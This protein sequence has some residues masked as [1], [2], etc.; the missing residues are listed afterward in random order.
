MKIK[1]S[2][3]KPNGYDWKIESMENGDVLEV[4]TPSGR[5]LLFAHGQKTLRDRLN[6]EIEEHNERLQQYGASTKEYAHRNLETIEKAKFPL[7]DII[8]YDGGSLFS[9]ISRKNPYSSVTRANVVRWHVDLLNYVLEYDRKY[10]NTR[11][12][13]VIANF[14]AHLIDRPSVMDVFS[15]I[16]TV[17]SK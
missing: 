5:Y 17:K 2:L 3:S 6:H 13:Q 7:F 4:T 16:E 12:L 1:L 9:I 10:E 15:G 14:A 11:C 8:P